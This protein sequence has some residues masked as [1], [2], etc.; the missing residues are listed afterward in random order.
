MRFFT[1][2]LTCT[3]LLAFATVAQTQTITK[4]DVNTWFLVVNRVNISDKFTLTNELHERTGSFLSNQGTVIVRP[5][6]DYHLQKGVELSLGYSFVRSWPYVPYSQPIPRNEHNIWEQVMLKSNIGKVTLQ[7]RFRFEQRW[8]GHI[9]AP[10]SPADEHY[11]NGTDY[12]NRFRYRF[13]VS[14]DILKINKDRNSIFFSGFDELWI[15]QSNN[16]M[17]N[18]FARNWL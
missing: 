14:F 7:H 6:V 11:I 5:S 13:I 2:V 18:S 15:N 17:P 12:A 4:G 9:E 16:F 3:I 8:I 10:A 1:G